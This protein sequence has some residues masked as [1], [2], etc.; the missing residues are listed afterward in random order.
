MLNYFGTDG[1]RGKSFEL[2]NANLAFK[3]GQSFKEV[4]N[5]KS[6]VIG[7]DT[8][9]SSPMLSHMIAAGALSVGIDV[10]YAGVV[11][12][13]MIAHYSLVKGITGVMITASHNPYTDN[14]IKVFNKGYK[15][16]PEEEV[17]IE[18]Y[19]DGKEAELEEFGEFKLS[20]DIEYEYMKIIDSL[21][22]SKSNLKVAY[23]S[24]NGANYLISNKIMNKYFPNSIQIHN[25]PNGKN[26]NR[27][28]GSTHLE[29]LISFVKENKMDLGFAY[30]GD[31]DR[32]LM[33]G[34][35][36][37]VYDG[38]VINYIIAT[39]LKELGELNGNTV[40][41]TKMTNP[42]VLE[43]LTNVGI[44]YVLTDVGDKYVS[45]ELV[46]NNYVLGGE[47][48]GHIIIRHLLHSG[49]GLLASLYILKTLIEENLDLE[50]ITSKIIQYPLKLV[51]I[52]NINKEVLNQEHV[53]S[54]LDVIKDS[55]D[56]NDIFLIRP[57][58]T[59]PLIRVTISCKDANKLD[60]YMDQ[61]VTYLKQEGDKL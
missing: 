47:S 23:D 19:I 55:F 46:D 58:G 15:S 39:H 2:L 11:S 25:E 27:D 22:L 9:D 52:P 31:G 44:D 3:I 30:D 49:D 43:A 6:L 28:C 34:S 56:K 20:D 50:A 1:I 18:S 41:L 24:A 48:S 45:K 51:N 26:I 60:T 61:V 4:Y 5:T 53:T 38:D 29:S 40:V 35:D 10:I 42:G 57:S 36:G 59:E 12:T 21:K 33:V 32:V 17:I 13:P 37:T 7:L 16:T 14:G 8:R 54:Y